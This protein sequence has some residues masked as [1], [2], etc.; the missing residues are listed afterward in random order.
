MVLDMLCPVREAESDPT[1]EP[2]SKK[3]RKVSPVEDSPTRKRGLE[4]YEQFS[5]LSGKG[6]TDTMEKLQSL[7]PKSGAQNIDLETW[8]GSFLKE[9]CQ[10]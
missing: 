2:G 4:E 10:I 9:H 1:D 6:W 8:P 5:T 7:L 3:A